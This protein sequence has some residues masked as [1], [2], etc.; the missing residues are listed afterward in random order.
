MTDTDKDIQRKLLKRKRAILAARDDLIA[1]T[2]LMMPDPNF[3]DDVG[4]SLYKPQ[5]F[6]R[7]IGRSLEEADPRGREADRRHRA[8][9]RRAAPGV[10]AFT[11]LA[12]NRCGHGSV[13]RRQAG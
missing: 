4:Q 2:Q 9:S 5:P 8:R 12:R 1:F 10:A 13:T 11:S 3:D 7:M 6:H